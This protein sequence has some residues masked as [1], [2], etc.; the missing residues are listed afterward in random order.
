[1]GNTD[2]LVGV[3]LKVVECLRSGVLR[4]CL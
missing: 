1:V 2:S 4:R 3:Q